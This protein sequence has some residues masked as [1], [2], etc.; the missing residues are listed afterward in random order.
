MTK[1][2]TAVSTE[3]DSK[4]M[5]YTP[6]GACD[7]IKLSIAIIRNLVAVK[8]RSGATCSENDAIKFMMM[9]KARLLNPFEGDAFL[10]GY[11]GKDGPTFS[12]ITAHQ[13]FLKRAELNKEYDGMKSGVIVE[14]DGRLTEQE[15]DFYTPDQRVAGGWA[16]VF[17]KNRKVP[18]HKKVRLERFKKNFGI[19]LDDAAGMI[20]KC[21]EAD[22]LRS[23]FPTM[24]GGLYL[25][26]ELAIREEPK[27]SSPIFSEPAKDPSKP[28]PKLTVEPEVIETSSEEAPPLV[29]QLRA[30]TL[31][32]KKSEAEVVAGLVKLGAV[33]EECQNFDDVNSENPKILELAMDGF[34]DLI[35]K[36]ES[37]K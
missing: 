22:A 33:G 18:M 8:T 12:L 2:T 32:S 37:A 1:Q 14:T 29:A 36:M 4:I 35:K 19:W 30:K 25:K 6:Y 16:T 13:A 15:G 26:E 7:S 17:F 3:T 28:E 34:D 31:A 20:C 9:C 27:V 24:L 23:S 10:I 5:E 11:D 21:A